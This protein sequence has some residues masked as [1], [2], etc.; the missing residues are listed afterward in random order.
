M[1]TENDIETIENTII[2]TIPGAVVIILFGSYAQGTALEDSD[3]DFL[4]LTDRDYERQNKLQML[5]S[6][7][8]GAAPQWVIMQTFS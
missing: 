1:C 7:R 5:A 8:C 3:M 4:I 2:Q 6:L